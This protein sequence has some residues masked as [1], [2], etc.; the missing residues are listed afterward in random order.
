MSWLDGWAG[1]VLGLALLAVLVRDALQHA[2]HS[3]DQEPSD[4]PTPALWRRYGLVAALMAAVA[5]T[6]GTRMVGLLT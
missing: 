5:A 6:L 1:V 3:P 2:A 4:Q